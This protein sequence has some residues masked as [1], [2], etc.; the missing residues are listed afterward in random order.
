MVAQKV[1]RYEKGCMSGNARYEY[2]REFGRCVLSVSP[3][4]K[5]E[6]PSRSRSTTD[7]DL[8]VVVVEVCPG[9]SQTICWER[10]RTLDTSGVVLGVH[11]IHTRYKP[12]GPDT[13]EPLELVGDYPTAEHFL[14]HPHIQTRHPATVVSWCVG[15]FSTVYSC[16]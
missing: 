6:Y 11:I 14:I 3:S 10:Y 9:F 2:R 8:K 4:I 7:Y 1:T 16:R 13:I 5:S 15:L 12:R